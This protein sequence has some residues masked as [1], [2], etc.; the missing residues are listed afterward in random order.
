MNSCHLH[1]VTFMQIEHVPC[2]GGFQLHPGTFSAFCHSTWADQPC[3]LH[4]LAPVPSGLRRFCQWLSWKE[5]R[6]KKIGISEPLCP[7]FLPYE[8]VSSWLC[9][10]V[11][12][13][14]WDVGSTRMS[15]L[16]GFVISPSSCPFGPLVNNNQA[17]TIS[18]LERY[19]RRSL[20]PMPSWMVLL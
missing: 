12:V 13:S 10:K 7:W 1:G 20:I 16:T 17:V 19:P 2:T 3:A 5:I 8:V 14:L 15:L 4:W 11:T 18:V 9:L 6:G